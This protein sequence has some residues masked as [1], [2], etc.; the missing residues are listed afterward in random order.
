MTKFVKFILKNYNY[1]HILPM[2]TK[3]FGQITGETKGADNNQ[4]LTQTDLDIGH[5]IVIIN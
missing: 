2:T 3:N 1:N 4:V 5:F